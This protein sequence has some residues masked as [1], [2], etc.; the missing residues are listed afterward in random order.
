MNVLGMAAALFLVTVYCFL[1]IGM[2]LFAGDGVGQDR[3]NQAAGI[4]SEP[5]ASFCDAQRTLLTLFQIIVANNW[6]TLMYGAMS[7]TGDPFVSLYFAIFYFLGPMLLVS[8]LLAVFFSVFFGVG[9]REDMHISDILYDGDGEDENEDGN[10]N[11]HINKK[12]DHHPNKKDG[13]SGNF[14]TVAG[15]VPSNTTADIDDK[16]GR[17]LLSP[18]SST[19][20]TLRDIAKQLFKDLKTMKIAIGSQTY[21]FYLFCF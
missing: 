5:K 10:D 17:P 3:C 12:D 16:Q 6:Q 21:V 18:T 20:L 9:S 19:D 4:R 1:V 7:G 13:N 2:E 8:L 11:I 15:V 14:L